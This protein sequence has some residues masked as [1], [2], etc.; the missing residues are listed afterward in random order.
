MGSVGI[1]WGQIKNYAYFQI[2]Y[3]SNY[4]IEKKEIKWGCLPNFSEVFMLVQV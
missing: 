2:K 4:I 1:K 3:G